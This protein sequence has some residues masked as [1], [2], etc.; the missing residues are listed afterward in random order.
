VKLKVL[1]HQVAL[2]L[3]LA[4]GLTSTSIAQTIEA[5][6]QNSKPALK[7]QEYKKTPAQT[8]I[9]GIQIDDSCRVQL[10]SENISVKLKGYG[11]QVDCFYRIK[12]QG[13]QTN[14]PI[15]ILTIDFDS[16]RRYAPEDSSKLNISVDGKQI[17]GN[18]IYV[19]E[20]Q[21]LI[22]RYF[23]SIYKSDSTYTAQSDSLSLLEQELL[24]DSDVFKEIKLVRDSLYKNRQSQTFLGGESYQLFDRVILQQNSPYYTFDLSINPNSTKTFQ[25]SYYIPYPIM[26]GGF[27][28]G[29]RDFAIQLSAAENWYGNTGSVQVD[30][31]LPKI[32]KLIEILPDSNL[33]QQKRRK[34]TW[35]FSDS[36]A[37][38]ITE[39]YVKYHRYNKRQVRR[40]KRRYYR[41]YKI[42]WL[43]HPRIRRME[44]D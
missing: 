1:I 23:K 30:I 34:L 10:L 7:K 38:S 5:S 27:G 9:R 11:Y 15:N 20:K 36:S 17:A 18:R 25:L 14:I 31:H 6:E 13:R 21:R 44:R 42:N 41:K 43:L 24:P 33:T 39:I 28:G 19:P 40:F 2:L 8:T 37:T 22:S 29:H 32:H 4:V 26:S 16:W 3:L 12:N 35:Q